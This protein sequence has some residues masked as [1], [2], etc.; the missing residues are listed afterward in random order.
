VKRDLATLVGREHDVLVIGG[1]IHGAFSA[2][3][4]AQRGLKTAL[5]EAE[6]F[7]A[8]TSW[9]SLKTIHGGLRYLQTADLARMR[10]SIRERRTLLR[11]AP[12]L[13]RPLPFL[14]PTYGHGMKGR[15]ALAVA[16][17]VNDLVSADR[18]RGLPRER[19]IPAGRRLDRD[20][21]RAL[22][23]GIPAEGLTGGG[24][25]VDAQVESSERLLIGV[26]HAAASEG[27]V[28]A[29]HVR[30]V[31][32]DVAAGRVGVVRVEDTRARAG[33]EVR[34]RVVLN[35]AG[36]AMDEVLALAGATRAPVPLLRAVNLVL[37]RPVVT[38]CAVGALSAGRYLFL[39]PWAGRSMAGTHYV[40]PDAMPLAE[41]ALGFL[42]ELARAY[43]WA[44][45]GPE[46]VSLVH[47]GRVPGRDSRHLTTRHRLID[48]RREGLDGLVSVQGVK[49]TTA[50][51]VAEEAV[52]HLTLRLGRNCRGRTATTRLTRAVPLEG[53]LAS[54]TRTAVH[55]EMALSLADAMLRRLDLGTAGPP[56]ATDVDEVARVLSE[57]LAWSPAR[58]LAEREALAAV[59]AGAAL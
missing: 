24:L 41:Q 32:I 39:V 2:W 46:D 5:V 35:A 18:N 22:V 17:L 10:E 48:H 11:I 36:P 8:G 37:R 33:F 28:L 29:N 38:Q 14:V 12:A 9:N 23:P 54:R 49:Y 3:D 44:G 50:R 19:R 13:V 58:V 43:P 30:V 25:W 21:L 16:L 26:L 57:E 47:S 7:G 52:D 56:A 40:A 1:G 45:L 34:A 53:D 31:G 4:A 51:A 20:E 59:F 42:A 27:A 15:E 55:E 6:D